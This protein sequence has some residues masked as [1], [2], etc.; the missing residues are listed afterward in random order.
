MRRD[1]GARL[2]LDERIELCCRGRVAEHG[3]REVDRGLVRLGAGRA[4]AVRERED[5]V[6]SLVRRSHG[7]LDAA[8]GEQAGD[9][10]VLDAFAAQDEVEVGRREAVQ[11]ALALDQNVVRCVGGQRGNDLAAPRALDERLAVHNA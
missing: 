3:E 8:V 10:D 1:H 4:H 11:A 9:G 5:V 7:S 2:S 6:P